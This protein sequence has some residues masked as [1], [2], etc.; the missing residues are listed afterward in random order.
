MMN[1]NQEDKNMQIMIRILISSISNYCTSAEVTSLCMRITRVKSCFCEVIPYNSDP[2][3]CQFE[4][5]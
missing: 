4:H 3:E 1:A 5:R 2:T